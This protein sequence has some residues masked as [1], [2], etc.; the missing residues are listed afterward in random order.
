MALSRTKTKTKTLHASSDRKLSELQP[1]EN[2]PKTDICS[3]IVL[4]L[5]VKSIF[6]CNAVTVSEV[7]DILRF[8][9]SIDCIS[10]LLYIIIIAKRSFVDLVF[11][12]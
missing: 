4:I 9:V 12:K 3:L 8:H 11:H 10:W 2:V 6:V 5:V 7:T 1:T